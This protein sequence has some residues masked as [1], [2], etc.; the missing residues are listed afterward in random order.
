[1]ELNPISLRF[2]MNESGVTIDNAGID[3]AANGNVDCGYFVIPFKCSPYMAGGVVTE[4]FAGG[5]SG[6]GELQ[7]DR[8]QVAGSDTSRG[9]ADIGRLVFGVTGVS[10]QGETCY[11]VACQNTGVT[12]E[13]GMEV[14]VQQVRGP[15]GA[16]EAGHVKPFLLVRYMPES[17]ANLASL[18]ETS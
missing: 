11:D 12:L 6:E 7:F 17:R 4:G 3:L 13:P 14:I 15:L 18:Q 1:M 10:A 8:R 2:H 5:T 16:G 9:V